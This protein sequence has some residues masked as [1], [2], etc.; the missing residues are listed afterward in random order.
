MAS[1]G[2]SPVN[3]IN[4]LLKRFMRRHPRFVYDKGCIDV[5]LTLYSY[6]RARRRFMCTV[7]VTRNG[8]ATRSDTRHTG[9]TLD[10][11]LPWQSMSQKIHVNP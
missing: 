11:L 8:D 10:L 6:T 2:P 1:Q 7:S 4:D 9:L 5:F 3:G